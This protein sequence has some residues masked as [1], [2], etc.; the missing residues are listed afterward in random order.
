MTTVDMELSVIS[1]GLSQVVG[2][3]AC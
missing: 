2:S 1:V 3:C